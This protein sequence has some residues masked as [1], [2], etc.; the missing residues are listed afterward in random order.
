MGRAYRGASFDV[1]L[2]KSKSRCRGISRLSEARRVRSVSQI[3]SISIHTTEMFAII[4]HSLNG[5][6]SRFSVQVQ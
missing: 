5:E 2:Q 4:V 6:H 1:S 3:E